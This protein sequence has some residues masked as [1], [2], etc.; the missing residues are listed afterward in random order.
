MDKLK[1]VLSCALTHR[2]S[3]SC[4]RGSVSGAIIRNLDQRQPA[5]HGSREGSDR[6]Y[7]L[8][9]LG[10][11]LWSLQSHSVQLGLV[12]GLAYAANVSST[13]AVAFSAQ[14]TF[15]FAKVIVTG[16]LQG[17]RLLVETFTEFTDG[18]GRSNLYTTDQ[19]AK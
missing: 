14:Y 4:R 1:H 19:M 6:R 10:G 9:Y 2:R 7:G 17:S 11:H 15:S 8:Q 13:P 5:H 16:Q 12:P 3:R 18:S